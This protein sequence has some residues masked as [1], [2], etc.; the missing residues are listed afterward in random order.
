MRVY[1]Q[2][3]AVERFV[4]EPYQFGAGNRE[5]L[6]S[7]AFWFYY[8]F[9]FR[10]V[11]HRAAS[12]AADQFT[13]IQRQRSYRAPL[14]VMRALTRCNVELRL[15]WAAPW[16][17]PWPEPYPLSLAVSDRIAR[18]FGGDRA[19]A[20]AASTRYTREALR[21]GARVSR[22]PAECR[23]FAE[24]ALLVAAVPDL[25]AWPPG[26]RRACAALMFAKGASDES[27]Y[28]RATQRHARLR[29]ALSVM[30]AE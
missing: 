1:R 16:A 12:I 23:A 2:R 13:R 28:L 10:P 21:P 15:P 18:E 14:D 9:G 19:T 29:R 7:G 20:R 27:A 30:T 11:E 5:G 6:L 8:R 17:D 25:S 26:E 22:S 24:L 4:V 3:F